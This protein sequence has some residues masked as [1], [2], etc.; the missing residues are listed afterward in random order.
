MKFYSEMNVSARTAAAAAAVSF[1]LSAVQVN[2]ATV[3]E[4]AVTEVQ[5]EQGG[6]TLTGR[7]GFGYL[8]SEAHEY[9]Y[10]PNAGGHT[11]SELV[12]EMEPSLMIGIGGSFRP[13][14][15]LNFGA[16][17][18]VKVGEGDGYMEDYDWLVPGLNWTD[19]S[20]HGN[21]DVTTAVIF[22]INA[23]FS[24]YSTDR[25]VLNC[26]AGFRRD[27]FEWEARGGSYVYSMN[28]FRDTSGTFPQQEL[29][30]TYE[31]VFDVPYLGIGVAGDLGRFHLAAKLTGSILVR[32]ETT[33]H[34]HMRDI[35][36]YGDF[37][38]GEMWAIDVALAYDITD[39]IGIRA[40]YF[41]EYYDTMKGNSRWH[42][43]D[44]GYSVKYAN[45][46]GADLK[47]SMFSM[48]LSYVF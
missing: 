48:A 2:A 23:E 24:V 20:V 47:T 37:N 32:G 44:Y 30:I 26:I 45:N 35:V 16:D 39:C 17:L 15:W 3:E 46:A 31:Q 40:A 9:L 5:S 43:N 4:A 22:D 12:W 14:P 11:A 29:A 18:W 33:D 28:S 7:L 6:L 42:Y 36:S 38:D 1:L 21:T 19:K 13:A 8:S 27:N 41:Y 25:F 10:W 34:H